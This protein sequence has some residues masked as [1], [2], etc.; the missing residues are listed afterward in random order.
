MKE[1]KQVY[2]RISEQFE[3]FTS[4][5]SQRGV[6]VDTF[7]YMVGNVQGLDIL[8]LACGHGF[9]SRQLKDWGAAHVRGVD[10]SP[11]MIYHARQ[12]NDGIAYEVR[13]VVQMGRIGS[14]DKVTAAWLFNYAGSVEELQ[15]MFSTVAQNLKPGGQLVAYTANPAFDLSKGNFTRYGISVLNE[16]VVNGGYRCKAQFMSTPPA[17]FTYYRWRQDVYEDA[18]KA[19]GFSDWRWIAPLISKQRKEAR[20][21]G[22]WDGF[23]SNSLQ[24]GLICRK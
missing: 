6:E 14:Y 16:N 2:E 13:D 18:I 22:Y 19:A 21:P 20:E 3:D 1:A 7:R 11:S 23:E 4:H 9:F 10:I 17:D 15:R 12:A 24:I 5:A 8:D